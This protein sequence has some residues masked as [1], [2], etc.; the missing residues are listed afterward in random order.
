M[1][2]NECIN[3][4]DQL[5]EYRENTLPLEEKSRV[6]THLAA[7]PA[8]AT[9]F[10]EL[11]LVLDKLHK[12]PAI[13]TSKDFTNNLLTRIHNEQ[14]ETTWQRVIG[15]SYTRA[16]SLAIA[17]G[18]IVA[19]GLNFWIDPVSPVSP[20]SAPIY[21]DQETANPKKSESF[22]GQLDSSIVQ[23]EDSLK[24]Q[25]NSINSGNKTLQLVSDS[26]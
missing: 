25:Q 3:I 1:Q 20:K 11:D 16:A 14:Q 22:A 6:D 17:A 4:C 19:I 24:L 15:S 18:L 5:T 8:C 26:K 9:V 21:A 7:C 10:Q 13:N 23:P 2:N 12:L